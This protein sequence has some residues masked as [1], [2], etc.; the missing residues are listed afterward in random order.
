M[1]VG[2]LFSGIG[3]IDL[4][5]EWSA[6]GSPAFF[7]ERSPFCRRV[8]RR[9]WPDVVC[10]HDVT[11]VEGEDAAD[12]WISAMPRAVLPSVDV[13]VGGFPCQDVSAAGGRVGLSGARSGLWSEFARLIGE[14]R[15][16]GVM[17]ENVL[18]LKRRG[19]STVVADLR[20]MGYGVEVHT[21]AALDV[22]A[23][24]RRERL[25]ILATLGGLPD[26][27]PVDLGALARAAGVAA[28]PWPTAVT[29]DAKQSRR[30]TVR[31]EH[32]TSNTG[33]T[34]LDAVIIAGDAWRTPV[35]KD[36]QR[37]N[38]ATPPKEGQT[39]AL[40]HEVAWTTACARDY[41]SGKRRDGKDE[42]GGAPLN[43]QIRAAARVTYPTPSATPYGSSHNGSNASR[44]SAGTPSLHTLAGR[45]G[46]ELNPA[47]V[48]ALMGF[49]LG[50]TLIDDGQPSLFEAPRDFRPVPA[51]GRRPLARGSS[52]AAAR[53]GTAEGDDR[54]RSLPPVASS[55]AR[56]RGSARASDARRSKTSPLADRERLDMT[57]TKKILDYIT[58]HPMA[59]I[60]D[61]ALVVYGSASMRARMKSSSALARLTKD[62][63]LER[64]ARGAYRIAPTKKA[65]PFTRVKCLARLDRLEA[66]LVHLR[67]SGF[68]GTLTIDD[69]VA[70]P[71]TGQRF[72]VTI[73]AVDA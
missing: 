26:V 28:A 57:D 41:R 3:G 46:G 11:E 56:E 38:V 20:R 71:K 27:E 29:T 63:V 47:W 24:H 64:V 69:G 45:D 19:L 54:D 44:P 22:G 39:R 21:L 52:V 42:R 9:Q 53:M 67:G 50:W 65:K 10:F 48:E 55:R 61:V 17:V 49:P 58:R 12:G 72:E 70:M 36:A 25:F 18:G 66:P 14:M 35:T 60:E 34:L 31:G 73:R 40:A 37:G 8:L 7:V 62:G 16:K 59:P 23:P 30:E 15:P 68:R 4:G 13:L 43:E 6:L 2:S 5:A 32:W 51:R 1:R 33:T